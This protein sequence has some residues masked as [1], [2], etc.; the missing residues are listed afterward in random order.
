MRSF[1]PKKL[2]DFYQVYESRDR[3]GTY[4]YKIRNFFVKEMMGKTPVS[5]LDVGCGHGHFLKS[6]GKDVEL[7][8]GIDIVRVPLKEAQ[9]KSLL[10]ILAD[11]HLL[12]FRD[13]AFQLV[14]AREVI[15]HLVD[16]CNA[17]KEWMRVSSRNVILS[18]PV[19]D[20]HMTFN[21]I[22]YLLWKA[23][24]VGS[25]MKYRN[26]TNEQKLSKEAGHISVMTHKQLLSLSSI[27]GLWEIDKHVFFF[28]TPLILIVDQAKIPKQLR[29]LALRIEIA[30]TRIPN[31]LG[32]LLFFGGFGATIRFSC[33]SARFHD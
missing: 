8:V 30:T 23:R 5:V 7:R 2:F 21:A 18:C 33:T 4:G 27:D 3:S 28:R 20:G 14:T 19:K 16:P 25:H 17:L 29:K 12:P 6:L 1:T 11:A 31:H 9:R 13:Q 26:L 24:N 10:V 22:L 15:E 32:K